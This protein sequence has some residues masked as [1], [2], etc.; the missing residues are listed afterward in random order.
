[1]VEVMMMK[2]MNWNDWNE[3]N[4]KKTHQCKTDE[5]KEEA[6]SR[7]GMMQNEMSDW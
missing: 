4:V 3:V 1:M 6:D 2:K 5:M 7:D